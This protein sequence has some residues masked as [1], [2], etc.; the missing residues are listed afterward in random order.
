ML[1]L[2]MFNISTIYSQGAPAAEIYILNKSNIGI[3]VKVIPIGLV[4]NKKQEPSGT[5]LNKYSAEAFDGINENNFIFGGNKTLLPYNG[6]IYDP[7]RGFFLSWDNS[8]HWYC[9]S[10]IGIGK[11]KIEFWDSDPA[12]NEDAYIFDTL[13]YD[14]SDWDIGND[15]VYPNND[16]F[17]KFYSQD[18]ITFKFTPYD[19]ISISHWSIQRNLQIW[20]QIRHVYSEPQPPDVWSKIPN[21]GGSTLSTGF[22]TTTETEGNSYLYFPIDAHNYDDT[23]THFNPGVLNLNFNI[24]NGHEA[25]IVCGKTFEVSNNATLRLKRGTSKLNVGYENNPSNCNAELKINSGSKLW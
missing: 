8:T 14:L 19:E 18:S 9:D 23:Y 10:I 5:K 7:D 21:K 17:F 22:F 25:N 15:Y 6:I 11:Y 24:D 1:L 20:H 3:Y 16:I 2:L 4:F 12:D 13:H